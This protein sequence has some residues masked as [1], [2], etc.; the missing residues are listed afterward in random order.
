MECGECGECEEWGVHILHTPPGL[1]GCVCC[2][3]CFLADFMFFCLNEL[4]SVFM[5]FADGS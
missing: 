5:D 2:L 4:F 3:G 1:A